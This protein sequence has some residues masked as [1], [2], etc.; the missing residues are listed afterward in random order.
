MIL[1]KVGF[2][3]PLLRNKIACLPTMPGQMKQQNTTGRANGSHA[4]N[5]SVRLLFSVILPISAC[6]VAW[7]KNYIILSYHRNGRS[8]NGTFNNILYNIQTR[9]L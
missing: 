8:N 7:K 1:S 2:V 9:H 4:V 6:D 5:T 3:C